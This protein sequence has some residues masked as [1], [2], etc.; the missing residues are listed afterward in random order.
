MIA[1]R[2]KTY[3]TVVALTRPQAAAL[4]CLAGNSKWVI[5]G[6]E[7]RSAPQAVVHAAVVRRLEKM[8][9]AKSRAETVYGRVVIGADLVKLLGS[10][11]SVWTITPAGMRAI[12]WCGRTNR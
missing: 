1:Q 3:A 9:L 4:E 5:G 11:R 7:T 6:R 12:G 8:G 10:W 2:G